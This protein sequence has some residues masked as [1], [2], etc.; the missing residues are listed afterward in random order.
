MKALADSGRVRL[1]DSVLREFTEDIY[2]GSVTEL[3][4]RTGMA[5]GLLYNLVHGRVKSLSVGEY[6]RIFG[7]PPPEE[8]LEMVDGEYFRRMVRLWLYLNNG[9]SEKDLY[10][11]FYRGRK[12]N[13]KTDYRVFTGQVKTVHYRLQ[14]LMEQKFI[15]QGLDRSE[16]LEWI[17]EYDAIPTGHRVPYEK[18]EPLLD[19]LRKHLDAHPTRLLQQS[20]PRYESGQLKT[21]SLEIYERLQSLTERTRQILSTGQGQKTESLKEEIYGSRP[22]YALYSEIEAELDFLKRYAG[23]SAK[24]YLGRSDGYYKRDELRRIATWRADNI[25]GDCRQFLQGGPEI[26]LSCLPPSLLRME[27]DRVLDV[28]R[29]YSIAR[30]IDNRDP[31]HERRVVTPK[32]PSKGSYRNGARGLVVFDEIPRYLD[33]TRKGFEHFVAAN[34]D[35]IARIAVHQDMLWYLPVLYLNELKQNPGFPSVRGKYEWLA[36]SDSASCVIRR[37]HSAERTGQRRTGRNS[38]YAPGSPAPGTR[39]GLDDTGSDPDELVPEDLPS[40]ETALV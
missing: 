22:G 15:G 3:K 33:F 1:T 32:H 8:A 31:E 17:E 25:I 9:A 18:A 21:V 37:G 13:V 5:Y 20:L 11:E 39:T 23:K 26:P 19:Y 34:R 4:Q 2:A 16:I 38:V 29:C 24:R 30:L 28:V 7:K 14:K 10:E 12:P 6:R 27:I 36:A 35:V 40:P